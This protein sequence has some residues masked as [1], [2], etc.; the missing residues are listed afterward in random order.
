MADFLT[1]LILKA[2]VHG[3]IE[4]FVVNEKGVKI[5]MLQDADDTVVCFNG[6]C[7]MAEILKFFFYGSKLQHGYMLMQIK[8]SYLD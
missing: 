4:S 3:L 6:K 2:Q 7:E 8:R 1:Q 5:L